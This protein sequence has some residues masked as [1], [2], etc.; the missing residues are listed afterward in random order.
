MKYLLFILLALFISCEE[1]EIKTCGA[2][3][4]YNETVNACVLDLCKI[5]FHADGGKC[6]QGCTSY[7]NLSL[8]QFSDL[9]ENE[10]GELLYH[11]LMDCSFPQKS[12][13]KNPDN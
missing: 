7:R 5:P 3:Q 13:W 8:G 11:E 12:Y 9:G 6:N 4:V 2:D 10:K 1:D